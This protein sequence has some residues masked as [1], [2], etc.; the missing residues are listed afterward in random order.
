MGKGKCYLHSPLPFYFLF[1]CI[2][3]NEDKVTKI[4]DICLSRDIEVANI[5][6]EYFGEELVDTDYESYKEHIYNDYNKPFSYFIPSYKECGF[7]ISEE[8]YQ[9]IRDKNFWEVVTEDMYSYF[10]NRILDVYTNGDCIFEIKIRFPKLTVTN[11][12][13]KSIDITELYAR[14]QLSMEGLVINGFTLYRAEYTIEQ[15]INSYAHSH[16]PGRYLD[17]QRPC[18]GSGPI[19][20][21]EYELRNSF[22]PE[23]WGLFCYEL[24]KYVR[25]ESIK[26]GPYHRLESV[27]KSRIVDTTSITCYAKSLM[28][29]STYESIIHRFVKYYIL[30]KE[31]PIAYRNNNIVLG[32]RFCT[33]WINISR[34][35]IKWYNKEASI[36]NYTLL[37]SN[38][39][40]VILK[41]YVL[42]GDI[43]YEKIDQYTLNNIN[44]K[45]G[46]K[47]F[48]FK[49]KEVKLNIINV[50]QSDNSVFLL[51]INILNCILTKLL[52]LINFYYGREEKYKA[53]KKYYFI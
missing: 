21:T 40:P 35:F 51:S 31:I 27:N 15:W 6:S 10:A 13:D 1:F 22:S 14:L 48:T 7:H 29:R 43:V 16:L 33:F 46:T 25:T 41:E 5:V 17:W 37:L 34:E 8:E 20:N 39:I 45:I 19:A 12:Y 50:K 2:M 49:G 44:T 36:G 52:R 47:L 11:E 42:E 30:N 32:E 28:L 53:D 23:K 24:S 26:G 4:A 3:N 9:N 38:F 18:L